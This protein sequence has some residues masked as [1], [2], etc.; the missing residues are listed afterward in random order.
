MIKINYIKPDESESPDDIAIYNIKI[1]DNYKNLPSFCQSTVSWLKNDPSRDYQDL[2]LLLRHLDLDTHL[3]ARPKDLVEPDNNFILTIPN[4]IN[5]T[6]TYDYVLWVSCK[7]KEEALKELLTYHTSYEENFECLSK[8]GCLTN[9]SKD[10]D[11]KKLSWMDGEQDAESK[12]LSC[13]LKYNF[14]SVR[15][16][17]SLNTIIADL[18]ERLGKEP[19]KMVCG[20]Y[21]ELNVYALVIEGEIVS[22]IGWIEHSVDNIELIDFRTMKK[23]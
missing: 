1:A 4:R 23:I 16:I 9:N 21:G 3:I 12:I 10:L 14:V 15:P 8:T 18:I 22:P 6:N 7:S 17:D 11:I 20:K 5:D 19:K 13:E 2:E